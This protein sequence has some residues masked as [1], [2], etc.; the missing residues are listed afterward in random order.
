MNLTVGFVL[1]N[2]I[3]QMNFVEFKDSQIFHEFRGDGC[4]VKP[5]KKILGI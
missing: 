4:P 1:R 2:L 3:T 5:K